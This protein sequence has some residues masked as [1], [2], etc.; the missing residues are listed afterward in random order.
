M[1]R[2]DSGA[3]PEDS[4]SESSRNAARRSDRAVAEEAEAPCAG[5]YPMGKVGGEDGGN[6][7]GLACRRRKAQGGE[8][9]SPGRG[10]DKARYNVKLVIFWNAFA[11]SH[12]NN[13]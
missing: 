11:R 1:L 6:G 2:G 4:A 8:R 10:D 7:G 13:R 9:F 12:T 5:N 3:L